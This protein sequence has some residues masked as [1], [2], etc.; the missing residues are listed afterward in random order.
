MR[1]YEALPEMAT[2]IA[3]V[4]SRV[5]GVLS[6]VGDSR[7]MNLPA[8]SVF[9]TELEE[10]RSTGAVLAEV[11]N[12]AVAADFR[13][14]AVPTEL[15]RCAIAHGL[16]RGFD[17]GIAVV[18]PSHLQIYHI[19]GFRDIG[20][21]RSYSTAIHDPVGALSLDVGQFRGQGP[22]SGEL[23]EFIWKFMVQEN[24]YLHQVEAWHREAQTRFL[25]AELL[26]RLFVEEGKLQERYS[27]TDLVKLRYQW[28]P[29]L[30][31]KVF[32]RD[33]RCNPSKRVLRNFPLPI[34]PEAAWR[35][36]D[37]PCKRPSRGV[38]SNC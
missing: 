38:L 17:E 21:I 19:L 37:E 11:T 31:N 4:G 10:L 15:M 35:T 2:F 23:E 13:R 1:I 26:R 34:H 8:D 16:R 29:R 9:R 6:V 20:S 7:A 3:K 30:F 28:G 32:G 33:V 22:K 5:V 25:Q 14:S 12:Q 36:D 24:P 27:P 18:S